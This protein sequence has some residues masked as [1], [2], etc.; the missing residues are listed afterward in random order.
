MGKLLRGA[1]WVALPPAGA[2]ASYRAGKRKDTDRIVEAVTGVKQG[3]PDMWERAAERQRKKL[4]KRAL[5]A[6]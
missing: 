3:K 2:A 1:L 6:D 5:N 4:A